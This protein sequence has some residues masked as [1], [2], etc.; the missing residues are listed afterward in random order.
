MKR[1]DLAPDESRKT[2]SNLAQL[3]VFVANRRF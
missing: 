1:P 3:Q 2:W